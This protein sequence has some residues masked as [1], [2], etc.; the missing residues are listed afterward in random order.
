MGH[1]KLSNFTSHVN[2]QFKRHAD[3]VGQNAA[4]PPMSAIARHRGGA[5]GFQGRGM[6]QD[7]SHNGHSN[8]WA[9]NRSTASL[10]EW[11]FHHHH[12]RPNLFCGI[13]I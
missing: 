3:P 5:Q 9:G 7:A 4:E 10:L 12:H 13:S 8:R 1:L 6:G 11:W 2:C